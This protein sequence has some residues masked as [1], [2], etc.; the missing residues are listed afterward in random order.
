MTRNLTAPLIPKHLGEDHSILHSSLVARPVGRAFLPPRWGIRGLRHGAY[1]LQW[2]P[3]NSWNLHYDGT[4]RI[5][6]HASGVTASGDLYSH[7]LFRFVSFPSFR[8]VR[9]PDP[10]PSAG[11]PIFPRN[12]YRYYLRVTQILETWSFSNTFVMKFELFRFNSHRQ[13]LDQSGPA[14]RQDDLHV[15]A[16]EL[17]VRGNISYRRT[18]QPGRCQHRPDHNGMGV[19]IP[20]QGNA[21]N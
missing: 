11:I 16:V 15:G 21:G 4:M 1:Y 9:N 5:E 10:N 8:L 12:R 17:S 3:R 13:Q 7:S 14:Q 6:R 19:K 20:A 2:R 18:G